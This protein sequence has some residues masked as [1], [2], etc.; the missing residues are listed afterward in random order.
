L[1][2]KSA[3]R[4]TAFPP[5]QSGYT[6]AFPPEEMKQLTSVIRSSQPHL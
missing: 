2:G 1:T 6:D 3:G 4:V 5:R